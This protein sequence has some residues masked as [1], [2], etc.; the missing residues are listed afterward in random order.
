M[1]IGQY[2]GKIGE[3]HQVA[4]PKKFREK[5]GDKLIITKGFENCLIIVSEENWKTLL[6]G[7]EGKPFIDKDARELQRFLLGNATYVELD[8]KGRFILPEFL[9]EFAYIKEEIIFAGIGRFVE[10]WDKASFQK[11]QEDLSKNITGIAGRLIE[12]TNK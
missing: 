2:D 11:H 10:I 6:E 7:T 3:K 12:I 8:T 4:L 1:L 9:R 5:L